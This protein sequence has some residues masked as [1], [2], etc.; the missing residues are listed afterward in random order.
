MT[1]FL[2]NCRKDSEIAHTFER[3]ISR[4][5]RIPSLGVI[6][7]RALV[8]LEPG[9]LAPGRNQLKMWHLAS[10]QLIWHGMCLS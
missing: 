2:F 10:S 1:W 9:W 8:A 7:R 6:T 5:E 4:T 3:R